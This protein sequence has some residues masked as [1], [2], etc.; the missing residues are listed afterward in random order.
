MSRTSPETESALSVL[1]KQYALDLRRNASGGDDYPYDFAKGVADYLGVLIKRAKGNCTCAQDGFPD[2]CD[3]CDAFGLA[4][5]PG[6]ERMS[7]VEAMSL[8]ERGLEIWKAKDHNAKWWRRI[9]G[10]PISNDLL[11]NIAEE[12]A[13][14]GLVYASESPDT[15]T[16]RL[17]S[18]CGRSIDG[19]THAAYCAVSSPLRGGE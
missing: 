1:I 14:R 6:L 8:A 19:P 18:D 2:S 17:C 3:N 4:Q 12:F 10:T 15:S 11:V 5:R 7:F 16:D 9:D 13:R